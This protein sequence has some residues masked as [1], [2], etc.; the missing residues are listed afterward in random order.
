MHLDSFRMAIFFLPS[1]LLDRGFQWTERESEETIASFLCHQYQP[2][3]HPNH[4]LQIQQE[5]SPQ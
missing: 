5:P 3:G 1:F 2:Q 4:P